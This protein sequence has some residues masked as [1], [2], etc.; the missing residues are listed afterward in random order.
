MSPDKNPTMK[1][2]LPNGI[3][4]IKFKSSAEEV[5]KIKGNCGLTNKLNVVGKCAMNI[6]N[7]NVTA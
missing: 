2:T 4:L 1:I 6:W 3:T 5:N 7:G